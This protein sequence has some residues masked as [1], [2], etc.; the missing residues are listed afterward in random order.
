M[1][2][3]LR[4]EKES[5]SDFEKRLIYGKLVD[6]TLKDYDCTEMYKA[7]YDVD[8]STTEARK[9]CYGILNSI[10]S[11]IEKIYDKSIM[12]INDIHVPYQRDDLLQIIA[13]HKEEI[14]HLCIIGDFLDCYSISSF[15]KIRQTTLKE[16]VLTGY[17][18][19][20][21]IRKILN[22]N[23]KIIMLKGNHEDRWRKVIENLKDEDMQS[24]INPNILEMYSEGFTIYDKGKRKKYPPIENLTVINHWYAIIDGIVACHP[25][26]F[27][28]T[29]G[30]VVEKCSQH[31]LS[32]GVDFD[33]VIF[34]HTHKYTSAVTER[35]SNKFVIENCCMCKTQEY[36]DTGK[37]NYSRQTYGYTIVKYNT[38]DRVTLN[39]CKSYIL[40]PEPEELDFQKYNLEL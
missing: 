8:I 18:V 40:D 3:L 13:K 11:K 19:L 27:S 12:F 33:L 36:A 26:T 2:E 32:K 35:F 5:Q 34:A 4:R 23:Q 38:G 20:K 14:T 37:L 7:L 22:N 16:E 39:N 9:R 21:Q 24:F 17:E 25:L 29:K 31:F 15:S 30:S 10:N 1:K 28:N 6:N